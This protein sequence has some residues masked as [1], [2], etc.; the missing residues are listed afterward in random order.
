MIHLYFE[1]DHTS[2][3]MERAPLPLHFPWLKLPQEPRGVPK[4]ANLIEEMTWSG[5]G[6]SSDSTGTDFLAV[7]ESEVHISTGK[8][9]DSV[10]WAHK[11]PICFVAEVIC[12]GSPP[13][14]SNNTRMLPL[15]FNQEWGKW[16]LWDRW[17]VNKDY[18][19]IW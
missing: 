19:I 16:Y 17:Y 14:S 18:L 8:G 7:S 6:H 1:W 11:L 3:T 15:D 4:L 12:V 13:T 10:T 5:N 2:C 9:W